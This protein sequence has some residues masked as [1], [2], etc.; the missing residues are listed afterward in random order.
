MGA[1]VCVCALN[2]EKFF[3]ATFSVQ[4]SCYCLLAGIEL[5]WYDWIVL[6]VKSVD[7]KSDLVLLSGSEWI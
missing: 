6:G 2:S 3:S 7:P 1:R 4:F 5:Y